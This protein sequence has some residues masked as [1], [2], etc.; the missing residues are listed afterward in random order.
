ME[1]FGPLGGLETELNRVEADLF[2][3]SLLKSLACRWQRSAGNGL[4]F[5][6]SLRC[7]DSL[8]P[9]VDITSTFGQ[10]TTLSGQS[11]F[12]KIPRILRRIQVLRHRPSRYIRSVVLQFTGFYSLSFP[13]PIPTTCTNQSLFRVIAFYVRLLWQRVIAFNAITLW[14]IMT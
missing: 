1:I 14:H 7:L 8:N 9:N 3:H 12:I 4:L 6:G 5:L 2:Q 10:S 11:R 13:L